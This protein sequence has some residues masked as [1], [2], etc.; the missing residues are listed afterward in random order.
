MPLKGN[1]QDNITDGNNSDSPIASSDQE[2]QHALDDSDH[3]VIAQQDNLEPAA[4][5]DANLSTS[6]AVETV[7]GV[8]AIPSASAASAETSLNI[9]SDTDSSAP[10][11]TVFGRQ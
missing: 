9:S 7:P 10:E 5:P 2:E 6:G 4:N 3:T 1:S 8:E 11:N